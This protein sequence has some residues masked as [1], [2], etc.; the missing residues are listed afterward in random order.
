MPRVV[1]ETGVDMSFRRGGLFE[2]LALYTHLVI[3]TLVS[4]SGSSLYEKWPS[5]L[6]LTLACTYMSNSPTYLLCR[7][8]EM[9]APL[10]EPSDGI[11]QR[12]HHNEKCSLQ[13][14]CCQRTTMTMLEKTTTSQR[15]YQINMATIYRIATPTMTV[16]LQSICIVYTYDACM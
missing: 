15:G 6:G 16:I 4:I 8:L 14:S 2:L 11:I 1:L 12:K 3:F 9:L 10:Q 13:T 7:Y 5:A